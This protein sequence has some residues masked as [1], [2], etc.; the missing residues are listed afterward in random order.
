MK[1]LTLSA[2]A[3]C[4]DKSELELSHIIPKFV[5]RYLKETS[6]GF[7]RS[8]ENPNTVVQ[9]GEKHYMLCGKCEDLFSKYERS[10][11]I[12]YFM[13]ISKTISV[14]LNTIHGYT[15]FLHLLVGVIYIWIC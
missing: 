7:L 2:C 11:R 13:H 10:L 1:Q 9:D 3:L 5:L 6:A 15:I 4:Q 12:I 8:A 14:A